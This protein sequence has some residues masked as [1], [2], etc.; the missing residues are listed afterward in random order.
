M[1]YQWLGGL[2]LSDALEV[3]QKAAVEAN[4]QTQ[5]LSYYVCVSLP[6]S[7]ALSSEDRAATP[8]GGWVEKKKRAWSGLRGS[9]ALWRNFGTW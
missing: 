6:R 8:M 2:Q 4:L 5:L 9:W 3:T 1:A 7:R